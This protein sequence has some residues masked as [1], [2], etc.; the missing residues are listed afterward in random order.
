MAKRS[1]GKHKPIH[2]LHPDASHTGEYQDKLHN[3]DT[4]QVS[5]PTQRPDANVP[6][7]QGGAFWGDPNGQPMGM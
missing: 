4:V 1:K 3:P 5:T 2:N 6:S 7:P